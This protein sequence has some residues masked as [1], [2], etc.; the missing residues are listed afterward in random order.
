MTYGR[1]GQRIESQPDLGSK[2]FPVAGRTAALDGGAGSAGPGRADADR[3]DLPYLYG[4]ASGPD[5][6]GESPAAAGDLDHSDADA[7][8]V[9]SHHGCAGTV[10]RFPGNSSA[11][12][13]RRPDG[14]RSAAV[15]GG[16][17]QSRPAAVR[18][19]FPGI[20]SGCRGV[21]ISRKEPVP[22]PADGVFHAVRLRLLRGDLRRIPAAGLFCR[23]HS[24]RHGGEPLRPVAVAP[25]G[26]LHHRLAGHGYVLL[27]RVPGVFHL[28]E[29]QRAGGIFPADDPLRPGAGPQRRGLET[30][31]AVGR[32]A[33]AD[34]RVRGADLFPGLLSGPDPRSGGL[35][36]AAGPA[37]FD[38][39]RGS[40]ADLPLGPAPCGGGPADVHR[41]SGGHLH[42]LPVP[43]LAGRRRHAEG[44][45]VLR[46]GA[47]RGRVLQRLSG[48]RP[49][50]RGR[51]PFPLPVSAAALRHRRGWPSGISG[52]C[53]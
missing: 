51:P 44:F 2:T 11:E 52:L 45:L 7:S 1:V 40:G 33:G 48:L 5:P 27:H 47:G 34:V 17:V 31:A 29:S 32:G 28:A 10:R 26:G 37:V 50:G 19:A 46:R 14:D 30:A 6:A 12:P 18:P 43:D 3:P 42:G 8:A 23:D 9:P 22:G 53:G 4:A 41:Q 20:S 15:P 39:H 35:S 38:P 25:S 16:S 36:G 13:L 49:G 21:G 24:G